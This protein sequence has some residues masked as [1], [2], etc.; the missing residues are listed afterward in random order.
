MTSRRRFIVAALLALATCFVPP[1]VFA[2]VDTG[3]I[4]GFVADPTGAVIPNAQ[5]TA[6]QANTGMKRVATTSSEGAYTLNALPP[7]LYTLEAEARG[8]SKY[9]L[10]NF[11]PLTVG[12]TLRANITLTVGA[13]T[14]QVQV[15]SKM[16]VVEV[17]NANIGAVV[18]TARIDS[19]PLNARSPFLLLRVA[20]S[21]NVTESAVLDVSGFNINAVSFNG[22]QAGSGAF[23]MDGGSLNVMQENEVPV[24]PN[25]D[26][27]QEFRVNTNGQS[28]EYGM[29]GGGVVNVVTRNG[30]NDLHG[31]AYEYLRNNAFD[32][33]G[34]A[35]NRLGLPRNVLRQNQFGFSLG[36]PV[37]IPKIYHGRNKTF[38]FA[39]YEG[40]RIRTTQT[41]QTR[42][43]TAPE[44]QGDFSQ[45]YII[46]P[47]TRRPRPVALYDPNSTVPN[48]AGA[49]FIRTPFPGQVIPANRIDS[50]A[51]KEFSFVPRPNNPPTDVTNANNYVSMS[52]APNNIDQ[53][54]FRIDEQIGSKNRLFGRLLRTQ[55]NSTS[56]IATFSPD[57][58]VDP[59]MAYSNS[60]NKQFVLGDTHTF[61]PTLLNEFRFS[62]TREYLQSFPG[63]Y[64]RSVP[65]L[66]GLKGGYTG[67]IGP[68]LTIA[69]MT[70][71]GGDNS[72]LALRLQT[73]GAISD[74]VT[75]IFG[76]HNLKIGL[77]LRVSLDNNYQPGAVAGSFSFQRDLTGDPQSPTATGLGIAT[78][79]LGDV[80]SGSLNYGIAKAD[81]YRYYAGFAQDDY[82]VS[83]RLTLNLGLR[84]EYI[85]APSERFNRYSNFDPAKMN[86][87]TGLP[88]TIDYAGVGFG[89]TVY[90]ASRTNFAPRFGFA[91]DVTGNSRLVVRGAYG[92]FF[93]QPGGTLIL[94]PYM[95]FSTTAT[96]TPANSQPAFQLGS[97]IPFIN[98]PL[99]TKGGDATFL[100]S[101]ATFQET[102]RRSPYVQQ[103][104]FGVQYALPWNS[105]IEASYAGNH[106]VHQPAQ[107]YDF[108]ELNP[109]YLS[110]GL[111][112]QN[113]VPNP[114]VSLG[115][116]SKTIT[117]AQS[118]KPYP[119]YSAVNVQSP[120]Y[121]NSNYQSLLLRFEKQF[122][123]GLSYLV[124]FTGAKM[125]GD[126]G[127]RNS[128][129]LSS[130]LDAT[131]GN[132][133]KYDRRSCRSIEPLDVSRRL[134][135]SFVYELPFGH[136]KKYMTRGIAAATIGGWQ[137]NGIY[138]AHTGTPLVIT[139]ANN[140]ASDRP[141]Y[142]LSAKISNP[143]AQQWFNPD[144]FASPALYTF[145]NAPRTLPDV[146]GP[147]LQSFDAGLVKGF[148][149]WERMNLQ[150]RADA[151]N[152]FNHT[153]LGLPSTNFLSSTFGQITTARP[154]R[155]VQ[156]S[157]KLLW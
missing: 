31:T 8:F 62:I 80:S 113:S 79:L 45:T 82:K 40:V 60:D 1:P 102:N 23:V 101:A 98:A 143:T 148:H 61:T 145:G 54:M 29:N 75:K 33:N 144:A 135:A 81:G 55:K 138:E 10:K 103:W 123:N 137:I 95:G 50:V 13:L 2:Q 142:I 157:L 28:A 6:T 120:G 130:G 59:T 112:L 73:A 85:G 147:G 151:F 42:V 114:F 136:G 134:V 84:Y 93:Y 94:G 30:T 9:L 87:L 106:G 39:N 105:V 56:V 22:S 14:E 68:T 154:N 64:G 18:N 34:W 92:L 77:D 70:S 109:Q 57:N 74:T 48:P 63:S 150:F 156:L 108:N 32:A 117:L 149:I 20:A 52:P 69:D 125:I 107:G 12:Q 152:A 115:I 17:E 129:W 38:F 104:N 66:I 140:N 91:Y 25:I 27:V 71:L 99:G 16:A 90:E 127:L 24:M 58:P 4:T 153:N 124:S 141:N 72:K 5:V 97:G 15:E 26:M 83:R 65:A 7:G 76:R 96:Y 88:G 51:A 46:D 36:G 3:A 53:Y 121:G 132:N 126:M 111:A 37:E 139:G 133:A 128:S 89:N 131:C 155:I 44:I 47:T 116:F 43:P 122:S 119:A 35:N 49:G 19:L 78:F 21:V 118:L 100:G 11:G 86:S 41:Q 110:Q 67:V 146:R